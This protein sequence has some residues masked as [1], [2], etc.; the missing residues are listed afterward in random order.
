MMTAALVCERY[1][2]TMDEFEITTH[3]FI[4]TIRAMMNA[5]A[6]AAKEQR[7]KQERR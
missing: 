3:E 1:G 6:R 5:E 2:W 4:Y 7:K